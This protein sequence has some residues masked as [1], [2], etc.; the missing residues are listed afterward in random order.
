M[1]MHIYLSIHPTLP[2]NC[3]HKFILICISVAA[4]QI[5]SSVPTEL[6]FNYFLPNTSSDLGQ[7]L[8]L[9]AQSCPNLCNPMDC[10]P[11]S[12]APLSK[13]ILQ[14]RILEW[15]AIPFS[16]GIFPTQGSNSGLSHCRRFFTR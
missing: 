12:L 14:T 11:P 5:G 16:R 2:C 6:H 7:S 9:V 1:S 3:V 15:A 4:L 8:C 13:G 10:S